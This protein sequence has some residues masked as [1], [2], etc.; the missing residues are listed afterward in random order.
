M[1]ID[2][3]ARQK[4]LLRDHVSDNTWQLLPTYLDYVDAVDVPNAEDVPD[5]AC[6]HDGVR[7][8]CVRCQR[9]LGSERLVLTQCVIK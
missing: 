6:E 8:G 5:D 2:D 7:M 9:R 3:Q 1:P 4:T